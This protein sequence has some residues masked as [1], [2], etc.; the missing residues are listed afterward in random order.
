MI[1][2]FI[3][4]HEFI[5]LKRKSS[6]EQIK[7]LVEQARD[8]QVEKEFFFFFN[9]NKEKKNFF[10]LLFKSTIRQTINELK[11]NYDKAQRKLETADTNLKK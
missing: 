8:K 5:D 10:F 2:E 11:D 7:K 3:D 4:I 9:F 6:A 1:D